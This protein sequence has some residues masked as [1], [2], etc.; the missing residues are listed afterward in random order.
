MFTSMKWLL[1]QF[2]KSI[3]VKPSK[4]NM[5]CKAMQYITSRNFDEKKYLMF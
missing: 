1:S 5:E 3:V 4:I 2:L